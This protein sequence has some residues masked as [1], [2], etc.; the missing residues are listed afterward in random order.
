MSVIREAEAALCAVLMLNPEQVDEAAAIVKPEDFLTI[1]NRK[2]FE[3]IVSLDSD[4]HAIDVM[5]VADKTGDFAYVGNLIANAPY[6]KAESFARIVAENAHLRQLQQAW[7]DAGRIIN[8][9]ELPIADRVDQAADLLSSMSKAERMES[10]TA[11]GKELFQDWYNELER[12][13]KYGDSITG[14]RSGFPD[15]DAST[16][17]WHGGEMI[18]VAARPGMGK[19]NFAINLAWSAVK[20]DKCVLYF[21]LEM[22]KTELMHR[23][24]SQ[25]ETINYEDVQTARIGDADVGHRITNFATYG[26]GTRLHINDRSGHTMASIRTE[27]KRLARRTGLDMIIIDHIGLV[28]GKGE[29][30][31]KMTDISRQVKLL[32]KELNVPVM[33]LTQL[34]RAVEQRPDPRPKMSDLRDSGAIEQD[35]DAVIFPFR[36]I[37]PEVP[38][39]KASIGQLIIA[40]LRHGRTG[41]IPLI[42]QFQY[43]RFLSADKESLPANWQMT[44]SEIKS[45]QSAQSKTERRNYL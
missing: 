22:G 6:G 32:A 19:T 28:T 20:Q 17:G 26:I 23:F 35:A 43:C 31:Q 42:V 37:D 30:Y 24:A 4:K 2:V 18:V 36:E 25:A 40:K 3:A 21:S 41:I 12:L 9:P 45:T 14:I 1:E 11:S 33:A 10:K 39:E 38:P 13:F 27:S 34:N 15:L 16:K 5:S 29:Q 8:N 44:Y 7:H